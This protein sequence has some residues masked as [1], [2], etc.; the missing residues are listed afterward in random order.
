MREGL[1][2]PDRPAI[3]ARIAA[4]QKAFK[5]TGKLFAA[6]CGITPQALSNYRSGY[7]RPDF[8]EVAKISAGTGA[9]V[10]WILYGKD[11]RR[12]PHDLYEAIYGSD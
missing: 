10:D 1:D 9:P 3:A 11:K 6:R 12:L 4:L 2:G 5:L 8:D 7:R